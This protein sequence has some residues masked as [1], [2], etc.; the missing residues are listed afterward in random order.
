MMRVTF[1][2]SGSGGNCTLVAFG[3]TS[4][5]IDCGFSAREVSARMRAA[6]ED[7]A[8]L[9]MVFVTHEH[10]DHSRGLRVFAKNTGVPLMASD[11]T[12]RAINADHRLGGIEHET[13][14]A[15]ETVRIGELEVTPFATSHDSAEPLGFVVEAA[16]GTRLGYA[17]DTGVLSGSAVESLRGCD[18]LALEANHDVDMLAGGPYP[19][20]LKRRIA[21]NVGHLSNGASADAVERLASDRLRHVFAIHVSRT[22]NTPKRAADA[23]R[24]RLVAIGLDIPVTP[25][26]QETGVCFPD[27]QASLF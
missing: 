1:L 7:P 4:V 9:K 16:D 5:L 14:R 6:G 21:S 22:N 12:A 11:G 25:I 3:E 13:L 27:R 19:A 2:G 15:G 10:I 20:F 24:E 17:S 23:L 18:H 26:P 8:R